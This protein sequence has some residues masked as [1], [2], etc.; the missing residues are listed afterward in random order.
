M[1]LNSLVTFPVGYRPSSTSSVTSYRNPVDSVWVGG[2]YGAQQSS[3]KVDNGDDASTDSNGQ[4]FN[5]SGNP[6]SN[7]RSSSLTVNRYGQKD[8]RVLVRVGHE[9]ISSSAKGMHLYGVVGVAFKYNNVDSD[10]GYKALM[11]RIMITYAFRSGNS[12]A[13]Y[14]YDA[15]T[16]LGGSESLRGDLGTGD[17]LFSYELP[18][19]E[20]NL[21]VSNKMTCEGVYLEFKANKS[22]G[23]CKNKHI[24]A[25]VWNL[26]PL[27]VPRYQ[28]S[29]TTLAPS[30]VYCPV[31]F[32]T[33]LDTA[34]N[35]SGLLQLATQ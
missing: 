2:T 19:S 12:Y 15:T 23:C 34:T 8:G 9:S 24:T 13:K 6:Y 4:G 16:K 27:I 33:R 17:K 31:D 25:Q 3:V 21:V 14:V 26:T 35:R 5:I 1:A 29:L 30:F 28:D 22:P 20:K 32:E 11:N 10:S 7:S 18:A